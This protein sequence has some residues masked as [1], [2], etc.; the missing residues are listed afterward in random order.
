MLA[1]YS[2]FW[3]AHVSLDS[4]PGLVHFY[5]PSLD[6]VDL[7]I[8]PPDARHAQNAPQH[9]LST[10][11]ADWQPAKDEDIAQKDEEQEREADGEEKKV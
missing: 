3:N 8:N 1:Q 7:Q 5:L 11:A 6:A 9:G 10:Q 2:G 4:S